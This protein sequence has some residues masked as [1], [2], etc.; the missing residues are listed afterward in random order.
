[1][2]NG[3]PAQGFK[4]LSK[5]FG[6]DKKNTNKSRKKMLFSKSVGKNINL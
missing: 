4:K 5:T 2:L 1:L 6:G 3:F